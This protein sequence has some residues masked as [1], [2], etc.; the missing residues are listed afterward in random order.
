MAFAVDVVPALLPGG[1]RPVEDPRL[2][3]ARRAAGVDVLLRAYRDDAAIEIQRDGRARVVAR[4][5][6]DDVRAAPIPRVAGR[7]V[8]VDSRVAAVVVAVVVPQRRA[9]RL[10]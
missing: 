6:A 7:V 3:R 1:A 10:H 5:L 9:D 4:V 2:A 8:G